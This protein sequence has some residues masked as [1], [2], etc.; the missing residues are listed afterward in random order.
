MS[1]AMGAA[2]VHV[3]PDSRPSFRAVELP[4]GEVPPK[5]LH[6]ENTSSSKPADTLT[7]DRSIELVNVY[8]VRSARGLTLGKFTDL[9]TVAL[10]CWAQAVAIVSVAAMVAQEGGAA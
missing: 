1:V 3:W 5:P 9:A 7:A 2:R 6:P 8:R 4:G 10:A